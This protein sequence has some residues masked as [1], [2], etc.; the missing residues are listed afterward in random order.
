MITH[1]AGLSS[2]ACFAAVSFPVHLVVIRMTRGYLRRLIM[3]P[4]YCSGLRRRTEWAPAQAAPLVFTRV[5]RSY[6]SSCRLARCLRTQI[7]H[8]NVIYAAPLGRTDCHKDPCRKRVR[9]IPRRESHK[10]P[11]RSRS[12]SPYNIKADALATTLTAMNS[13]A[14]P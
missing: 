7:W 1:A 14:E 8:R 13:M 10:F 2:F 11:Q 6:R 3:F 4:L 5:V 9:L 12:Y